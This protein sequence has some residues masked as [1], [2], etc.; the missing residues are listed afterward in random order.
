MSD[1]TAPKPDA[2]VE[3]K[4]FD[5]K[6][7]SDVVREYMADGRQ[8]DLAKKIE[9]WLAQSPGP[10]AEDAALLRLRL[11]LL[12][13]DTLREPLRGMHHLERLLKTEPVGEP[14]LEA[15]ESLLELRLLG[16]RLAPLLA[17]AYARLKRPHD[18][19]RVLERELKLAHPPR[20]GEVQRRVAML[21]MDVRGDVTGAL[22]LLA[23]LLVSNAGDDEVRR[24]FLDI[25]TGA[26]R[27]A[28]AARALARV[29][30][31]TR[32][33]ASRARIGY[34]LGSL[35][36][37][38]GDSAAALAAFEQVTKSGSTED[39]VLASA[40]KLL[41]V[42]GPSG[43]PKRVARALQV[44]TELEPTPA[45][46]HEAGRKLA[47]LADALKLGAAY[48]I[49]AWRA[50]LDAEEEGATALTRLQ[51]LAES[52]GNDALL[53]EVLSKRALA[54]EDRESALSLGLRG[55]D[56]EAKSGN[57]AR[58]LFVWRKLVQKWGPTRD[59]LSRM[60]E[61][62]EKNGQWE[63]LAAA[64]ESEVGVAAPEERAALWGRIGRIR[65]EKL[66]D[67]ATALDAFRRSVALDPAEPASRAAL[68]R[69]MRHG[70]HRL[71][72]SE[73]LEPLYRSEGKAA[74]LMEALETRAAFS[75]KTPETA[76]A[77]LEEAADVASGDPRDAARGIE[78]CRRALHIAKLHDRSLL[79]PWFERLETF[80]AVTGEGERMADI[81]LEILGDSEKLEPE[82]AELA[83][84]VAEALV[85]RG[86]VPRARAFL[87]RALAEDPTSHVLLRRVDSFLAQEGVSPAER[88]ARYRRALEHSPT[89]ERR[90]LTLHAIAKIELDELK[91]PRAAAQTLK[92][93]VADHPKDWIAHTRL[94]GAY[95]ALG[96][97]R[98]LDAELER[99]LR[100]FSGVE[101][102][103]SMVHRIERLTDLGDDRKAT[104]LCRTLLESASVPEDALDIAVRVFERAGELDSV[105]STLERK[106]NTATTRAKKAAALEQLGDFVLNQLGE[107]AQ[108]VD[109][110]KIGARA[111]GED[112]EGLELARHLYERV[113][114]AIP[115][116]QE[117][118]SRLVELYAAAGQW[119]K[120]PEVYAICVHGDA[121][122]ERRVEVLL[123]LAPRAVVAGAAD[124]F[125]ALADE[126]LWK[127]GSQG[128][129]AGRKILAA[130]AS[131]LSASPDRH[132]E[133]SQTFRNLI[134][135]YGEEDDVRA[136]Y[137]FLGAAP[138]VEL[139]REG[140]RWVYPW[141]AAKAADPLPVLFEWAEVEEK[142]LLDI[143][144]AI[145]AFERVV[146][147]DP[148]SASALEH[149]ARLRLSLG[150]ATGALDALERL[151][152]SVPE[153]ARADLDLRMARVAL[154]TL[155]HPEDAVSYVARAIERAGFT[156]PV[157]S[158][159]RQILSD[160]FASAFAAEVLDARLRALE[161]AEAGRVSEW[162]LSATDPHPDLAAL[163]RGWWDR[164]LAAVAP[165]PVAE[166]SSTLEAAIEFPDSEEFWNRSE[167]LAGQTGSLPSVGAA[168]QRAL[169]GVL[170]PEAAER[171]GAR[172]A[173][174]LEQVLGDPAAATA[175]LIRALDQ[176]PKARWALDRVKLT[177]TLQ[178]RYEE[179]LEL[180]GRAVAAE[181]DPAQKADLL[182][183]AVVVARDLATDPDRAMVFLEQLAALRPSDARIETSLE[184][185]YERRGQA[186]KLIDLLKARSERLPGGERVETSKRIASLWLELGDAAS[187]LEIAEPLVSDPAHLAEGLA[188][189]EAIVSVSPPVEGRGSL[190]PAQRR[191]ARLLVDAYTQKDEPANVVRITERDLELSDDPAERIAGHQRI[192]DLALG[193]LKD[194]ARA[195]EALF[196]L[197]AL[198]PAAPA[199][200][201]R[202][203]EL[204]RT[205]EAQERL[206]SVLT[207]TAQETTPPRAELLLE[208]AAIHGDLLGNRERAIELYGAT[209]EASAEDRTAAQEAARQLER[210]LFAEGRAPERCSTLERLAELVDDPGER[211]TLLAEAAR[212]AFDELSDAA[213]AARIHRRV[214]EEHPTDVGSMNGL[215]Q[216]LRAAQ[217]PH[218]LIDALGMRARA[219]ADPAAARRDR[220][221]IALLYADDLQDP[222]SAV[223][224]WE[225][226]RK[227]FG[228]DRQSFD[229]LSALYESG[230]AWDRLIALLSAEIQEEPARERQKELHLRLAELQLNRQNDEVAAIENFARGE[231][232]DT[233][234]TLAAKVG[235]DASRRELAARTLLDVAQPAW[236][237]SKTSAES[238]PALA[239]SF[240][241]ETLSR[242]LMDAGR[243]DEA[244]ALCL[245]GAELP[246]DRKLR[247]TLKL[248]AA[249]LFDASLGA[250]DRAVD[251]LREL[252]A[253]D[254]SDEVAASSAER[255]SELLRARG[256]HAQEAELWESQAWR[257]NQQGERALEMG[258][259]D[260]AGA[261]WE[262]HA[263]NP[264]RAIA[265]YTQAAER[266]SET[267]L[268]ALARLHHERGEGLL[269][270]EALDGLLARSSPEQSAARA[271]QSADAY[272]AIGERGVARARLE[273]ALRSDGAPNEVR[274]RLSVLYRDDG[275][276]ELL[277][278]LLEAWAEGES[279]SERRADLFRQA[280]VLYKSRLS[281]TAAAI[282]CLTRGLESM[283][284]RSGAEN[285]LTDWLSEAGRHD[286]AIGVLQRR[287]DAYEG[288][289]PRER[290][291]VHRQLSE[292]LLRADR[293]E[294]A[295]AELNLAAQI[296]PT[297]TDILFRLAQLANAE[298]KL[299][300][301]EQTYR[302]LLLALRRPASQ[303]DVSPSL[304]EVYL[305]LS[306]VAAKKGD[307]AQAADFV[308][309][310]FDAAR[311]SER[312]ALR[313]EA[314]LRAAGRS[315]LVR[316]AVQAR[317][318]M[319]PTA[320]QG[321]H[322]L[323]ELVSLH[324]AA[325]EE[326][327]E[328][329]ASVAKLAQQHSETL[330]AEK[331]EE[332]GAF[333]ALHRVFTWLGDAQEAL[334][335]VPPWLAAVR[336]RPL[337]KAED[338]YELSSICLAAPAH[339]D[340]GASILELA[341][342]L[343]PD[344]ER[345]LGLLTPA[346]DLD[347]PS[348]R[349]LRF[350]EKVARRP[351]RE[352]LRAR[353]LA[354][355]A[356]LPGAGPAEMRAAIDH[357]LLLDDR[358]LSRSILEACLAE[359]SE[360]LTPSDQ[361][362]LHGRLGA[363]VEHEGQL[364]AAAEHYERAAADPD[365]REAAQ[366][367]RRAAMLWA[368]LERPE[369]ALPLLHELLND[370][371]SDAE[372]WQ[373]TL[374][375]HAKIAL[376]AE[377]IA[378]IGRTAHRIDDAERRASLLLRQAKLLLA[379]GSTEPALE[380]L[381][382][383]LEADPTHLEAGE[384]R[385]EVLTR[386]GRLDEVVEALGLR[387]HAARSRGENARVAELTVELGKLFER[388]SRLSDAMDAYRTAVRVDR[389]SV[390][391][392]DAIARLS[393]ELPLP[394]D[395]LSSVLRE[396]VKIRQGRHAAETARR[397][398]TVLA[399]TGDD[400]AA[401]GALRDA[402]AA[403]PTYADVFEE[404]ARRYS[405]R[406]Q[407]AELADLV[408]RALPALGATRELAIRASDANRRAGKTDRAVELLDSLPGAASDAEIA[409]R[410]FVILRGARKPGPALA[411]LEHAASLDPRHVDELTSELEHGPGELDPGSFER[412]VGA[413]ID[414]VERT[415]ASRTYDLVK[416]LSQA[417]PPPESAL[418]RLAR[419]EESAGRW[420][421]AIAVYRK[422]L[423][424]DLGEGV[425]AAALGLAEA[426][427]RAERAA[428]ARAD[429]E[430]AVERAPSSKKLRERL[431]KLYEK[432]GAR[433]QLARTYLA[434]AAGDADPL[435]RVGALVN[436]GSLLL[437]SGS[438]AQAAR[439]LE[440]AH[441]AEPAHIEASL[442]LAR[443]YRGEGNIGKALG[444]LS[445]TAARHEKGRS[446]DL[447]RLHRAI[448]D[449]H[450]E[451]DELVEAFDAARRGFDI[452][453][454]DHGLALTAG[455]L[456]VDLGDEK[457]ARIA[458]QAVVTAKAAGQHPS[459]V[460]PET[461]SIAYTCLARL[462]HESGDDG[463]ARLTV[464]KALRDDPSNRAAQRLSARLGSALTSLVPPPPAG[465]R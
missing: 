38:L 70:R 295:L 418:T 68:E 324:G 233:A 365:P 165:D 273:E 326:S 367:R 4:D 67:P 59:V 385:A 76:L 275:A 381:K 464:A 105:R 462:A 185:L 180:Y 442:L 427:E 167:S 422:L 279:G 338:G 412:H 238:G 447:A 421:D 310:A 393:Q 265:A 50:L 178:R 450:L 325:G 375:N 51:E 355:I 74:R 290:A 18:E 141:R 370:S 47:E 237:R 301:A 269:A 444:V 246:F 87:E 406:G 460:T 114:D 71:E 420:V 186:R 130:K 135:S 220:V 166:L 140:L 426:C 182:D 25:S 248:R 314:A 93:I 344:P 438:V 192:L 458:L 157:L 425:E 66:H 228:P 292:V 170:T 44:L 177:L 213:R 229:A 423:S 261:L 154:D 363:L 153:A 368:R 168:Y 196:S 463:R 162:L 108:A 9:A 262:A 172:A 187:A 433:D 91:S 299:L 199:H 303:D 456:A 1:P 285:E 37:T 428:D 302:T 31:Y 13:R 78:L 104:E 436:A 413:L 110:W 288:R 221:R 272:L 377:L 391:A 432:L 453:K 289:R 34:D 96:D 230:G 69:M 410:K 212:V 111:C 106:V 11:V 98:S 451:A 23:P 231:Q 356:A 82:L 335:L 72:A 317:L 122:E 208:A 350:L 184:R 7:F 139:R 334:A 287:I 430:K 401:E 197:I 311:Q 188:L 90:A 364:E 94:V 379:A 252:F 361:A 383:V 296:D 297:R 10:S 143:D 151:R 394:V 312:D 343:E 243:S 161:P 387:I 331:C 39:A 461:R 249:R 169:E 271:M 320:A 16:H 304:S 5:P 340:D 366:Q 330:R 223:A 454:S 405:E 155:S 358:A 276:W 351:G 22:E 84:V 144:G 380:A 373:L 329:R 300:D 115:T 382:R 235:E 158:L 376:P 352:A 17:E 46:R 45:R 443:A 253:D 318:D 131:V 313:L 203:T 245:S 419:L 268:E 113:L 129:G 137:V 411:A 6:T 256:L 429:L 417:T 250:P 112:P 89:G 123:T 56:L 277:A 27:S 384:L 103:L 369:R 284:D 214:L 209:L 323:A 396:L 175:V 328:L 215:V 266:G 309:S 254:P 244:A 200:R 150:D 280:A 259:W 258:L 60:S 349:A 160:P 226:I 8:R 14:A 194:P 293:H 191:A 138:D 236:I 128:S 255:F 424:L 107:S 126:A 321:A 36:L 322:A 225:S 116:D 242:S 305:G 332:A 21:R 204:A 341:F 205:P 83:R 402:F 398:S 374:E 440:R 42:L 134:D 145:A 133:A 109:L 260:R 32:D 281:D 73:V 359:G 195:L 77:L 40:R 48:S 283:P 95:R 100:T 409:H 282:R 306:E 198:E 207:E 189:L 127:T 459:G 3:S 267:A 435:A 119:S 448:A 85:A 388:S 346:L 455:L 20:L 247:R 81:A 164:K 64:L 395:E 437:D 19:L 278:R 92:A 102:Q 345:V 315:D 61:L 41:E 171:L 101:R 179:L 227:D 371:P 183:E 408:E 333:R 63:D 88:I 201:A 263:K 445:A 190:V 57:T 389:T 378:V 176:A 434:E 211:R 210:L 372:L 360:R 337:E 15:A 52:S 416:R 264:D 124:E 54:S 216:A 118:A 308:E 217:R 339:R 457:T 2:E 415:D 400:V 257:A 149:L 465:P 49:A 298:G 224:A 75:T 29:L 449:L 218:E 35:H 414:L 446:K 319:A 291:L 120:V 97:L 117:A 58:A 33:D 241:I 193:P 362:F 354:R 232:W 251:L 148:E 452:D 307:T 239:A 80:T 286:E 28:D 30:P 65:L 156:D 270:A 26:G 390:E 219:T 53:A 163:R 174:F 121:S 404:L 348:E 152:G 399:E 240:A 43:D 86:E 403:D 353:A 386:T 392:L 79:R 357:A 431:R 206:A 146:E 202:A 222:S 327:P 336:S 234:R 173:D 439:T 136:Y 12:Y 342:Q 347:P 62:L 181:D 24:R 397:L 125:I 147:H 55:A 274:E 441:E 159:S 407:W 316:R 294:A 99:G 132:S 142:Q